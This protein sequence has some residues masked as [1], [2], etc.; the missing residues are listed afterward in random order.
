MEKEGGP[1][2]IDID[3]D[4]KSFAL[5]TFHQQF[6]ATVRGDCVSGCCDL[7]TQR[8]PGTVLHPTATQRTP[9]TVL[10]P[11]ATQQLRRTMRR[12]CSHMDA[13]LH[14]YVSRRA[15]RAT[16]WSRIWAAGWS[17]RIWAAGWSSGRTYRFDSKHLIGRYDSGESVPT[18]HSVCVC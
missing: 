9:G 2:T 13:R 6:A 14:C 11:T 12:D 4:G 8:T 1:R 10:H 5:T 18:E 16:L 17:S 7:S 3:V 15:H